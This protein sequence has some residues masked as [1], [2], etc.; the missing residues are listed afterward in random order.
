MVEEVVKSMVCSSLYRRNRTHQP[1]EIKDVA[2]V[3]ARNSE[4]ERK[5]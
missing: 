2:S 4:C 3:A 1:T 5:D